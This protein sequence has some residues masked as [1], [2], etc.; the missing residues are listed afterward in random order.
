VYLNVHLDREK[1]QR[2]WWLRAL[3]LVAVLTA[4]VTSLSVPTQTMAAVGGQVPVLGAHHHLAPAG[5]GWGIPHP[6]RINNGGDPSG[7]VFSI[8]WHHWGANR[9]F[10][11]G[12]TYLLSR[13]AA[14]TNT[15]GGSSFGRSDSAD[16][17]TM[18]GMPTPGWTTGSPTNQAAQSARGGIA[19]APRT[20]TSAASPRDAARARG[21]TRRVAG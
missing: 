7:L 12:K 17:R 9:A 18:R 15:Q 2:A 14:F 8:N 13:G 5:S 1:R 3:A 21:P 10:G 20:E 11:H 19:G 16:V 4:A 6:H